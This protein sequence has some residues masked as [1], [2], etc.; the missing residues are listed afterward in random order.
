MRVKSRLI[1]FAKTT[2]LTLITLFTIKH[3][4]EKVLNLSQPYVYLLRVVYF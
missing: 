4:N 2:Q 3:Y 1:L